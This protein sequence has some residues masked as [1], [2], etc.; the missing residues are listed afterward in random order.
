MLEREQLERLKAAVAD[1]YR[2]H[3]ELGRGGMA[4]VYLAE[5]LRHDRQLALKVLHPRLAATLGT[6]RFLR[7]IKT[8]AS[9]THP[10][11]LQPA[12]SNDIE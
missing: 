9:L 12:A 6:S 11:I 2:I 3:R 1:R 4:T 5:E 7:E 10:H 8:T